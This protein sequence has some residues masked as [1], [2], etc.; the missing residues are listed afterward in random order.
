MANGRATKGGR[1]AE[2][3]SDLWTRRISRSGAGPVERFQDVKR[4]TSKGAIGVGVAV[5]GGTP[6]GLRIITCVA[7]VAEAFA[8]RSPLVQQA[9]LAVTVGAGM[10]L[11]FQAG[12]SAMRKH[13]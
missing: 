5:R 4:P 7:A 13:S 6:L 10:P 9:L 3:E 12:K 11:L 8:F 2:V 1:T